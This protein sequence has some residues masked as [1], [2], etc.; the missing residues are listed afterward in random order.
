MK[1][2]NGFVSNSSSSSFVILIEKDFHE[3][4]YNQFDEHEKDYIDYL[5]KEYDTK[6]EKEVV[7]LNWYQVD[8]EGISF[9]F[10]E[11]NYLFDSSDRECWDIVDDW[12][13]VFY[14]YKEMATKRLDQCFIHKDY[15]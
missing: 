8:S 14:K 9:E 12:D 7:V 10:C 6:F 4:I 1:I 3:E 11:E 15:T 13:E 5:I 2:R